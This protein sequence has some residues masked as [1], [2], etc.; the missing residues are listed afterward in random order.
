MFRQM[1]RV[2][3]TMVLLFVGGTIAV[4]AENVAGDDSK[5]ACC[6]RDRGEIAHWHKNADR[7]YGLFK[8]KEAAAELVKILRADG[9]NFEALVSLPALTSISATCCP[10]AAPIGKKPN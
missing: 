7:L 9:N 4:Q 2:C 8:P 5:V 3:L 1:L 10:T 6:N